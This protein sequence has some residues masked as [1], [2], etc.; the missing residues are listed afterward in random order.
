MSVWSRRLEGVL[1]VLALASCEGGSEPRAT[2][3]AILNGDQLFFPGVM[4]IVYITAKLDDG[5]QAPLGS[6]VMLTNEWVLTAA[7]VFN[8]VR[9]SLDRVRV[10]SA[11]M[12][13]DGKLFRS[14]DQEQG[15][16]EVYFHPLPTR[17][18]VALIRVTSPFSMNGTETGYV[19]SIFQG[20]TS[21]KVGETCFAYGYGFNT[22]ALTGAGILRW[23]QL[24]IV[25]DP[26]PP[27]PPIAGGDSS[28][29]ENVYFKVGQGRSIGGQPTMILRND[30]GGPCF[31][32]GEIIGIAHGIPD[33]GPSAG[34]FVRAEAF[35][36]WVT[37]VISRAGGHD[38]TGDDRPDILF[39]NAIDL[40]NMVWRM[41]PDINGVP[42]KQEVITTPLTSM[43]GWKVVG[44]GDF[45]G[46]RRAD[47]L[48]SFELDPFFI[49]PAVM[50]S[51]PSAPG[52]YTY[53]AI[54]P[55][56][57]FSG[58]TLVATGDVTGDRTPD[59]VF[60]DVLLGDNWIWALNELTGDARLDVLR[61]VKAGFPLLAERDVFWTIAGVADLD[62]VSVDIDVAAIGTG[63]DPSRRV[64]DRLETDIL[65]RNPVTGE[66]RVWFLEREASGVRVRREEKL[67]P[68]TGTFSAGTIADFTLDGWNDI[69][70]RNLTTGELVLWDMSR[71][72]PADPSQIADPARASEI[73]N[74]ALNPTPEATLL[75]CGDPSGGCTFSDLS[76][77]IVG[78]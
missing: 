63:K 48:I 15:V 23:A 6:G 5:T 45:N 8:D 22:T 62:R 76:W 37:H 68:L 54:L 10:H 40:T 73:E 53:V 67:P 70:W 16:R 34:W 64:H 31:S 3:Q 27:A 65:W 26:D 74:G 24:P 59:L 61:T 78:H 57:R 49:R 19:T 75:Q 55:F 42:T 46:D 29:L 43:V 13:D 18:D 7:H 33:S 1:L 72:W 39:R 25:A 77:E 35:R 47:V 30:S 60:R 44:T 71:F 4:G 36:D 28:P 41:E 56:P 2:R 38:F 52:G 69:L 21:T 12:T 58:W 9:G 51:D 20:D 32:D 11:G 17:V 66:N 50:L 14:D